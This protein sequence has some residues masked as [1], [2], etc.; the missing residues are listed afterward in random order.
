M[1][2]SDTNLKMGKNFASISTERF[3]FVLMRT[4][5]FSDVGKVFLIL[6]WY[7]R[8]LFSVFLIIEVYEGTV[9]FLVSQQLAWEQLA[10]EQLIYHLSTLL[11]AS[12]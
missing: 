12:L 5:K 6:S 10:W 3:T 4:E 9:S 2:F 7:Q 11:A 8:T 1:E